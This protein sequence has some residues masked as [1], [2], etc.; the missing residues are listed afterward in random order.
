MALHRFGGGNILVILLVP[1]FNTS[2]YKIIFRM[3]NEKATATELAKFLADYY[4]RNWESLK[5]SHGIKTIEDYIPKNFEHDLRKASLFIAYTLLCDYFM[6][7]VFLYQ[8]AKR[9]AEEKPGFFDPIFIKQYLYKEKELAQILKE[10]LSIRFPNEAARR[11]LDF[12]QKIVDYYNGNPIEIFES[13]RASEIVSRL[14]EFRGFGQKI[15]N[16]YFRII[17]DLIDRKF[18]DVNDVYPPIDVHDVRLTYRWGII[19]DQDRDRV[20]QVRE[21]WLNACIE[22]NVNWFHVDRMMWA[23]GSK[24]C[25]QKACDV[26]PTAEFCNKG[27]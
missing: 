4:K 14:R 25:F 19:S 6:K 22:A 21:I 20:K 17:A 7:S 15:G 2:C 12:S 11:W 23:I 24:F 27:L 16:L 26:C 13:E 9:F 10:N 1:N 18:S 5:Q 8:K 3:I